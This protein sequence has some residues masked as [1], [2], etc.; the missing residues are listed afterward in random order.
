MQLFQDKLWNTT[1]FSSQKILFTRMSSMKKWKDLGE[2]RRLGMSLPSGEV[3]PLAVFFYTCVDR[4]TDRLYMN[5]LL[6]IIG[7][8]ILWILAERLVYAD[9]LFSKLKLNEE[10]TRSRRQP[11]IDECIHSQSMNRAQNFHVDS[12]R[13]QDNPSQSNHRPD[14]CTALLPLSLFA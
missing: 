5:N 14:P 10:R 11:S 2:R 7:H 12:I 13:R 6:T 1:V 4:S 3:L 9:Y 8:L